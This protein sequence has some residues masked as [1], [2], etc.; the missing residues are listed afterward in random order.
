MEGGFGAFGKMPALG[1]FFQINAP[2]GFVRVWDDWLQRAM[3]AA[4][5]TIGTAWDD[6]YLS[7]PIW[8]FSLA[9]GIAGPAN[10][11]GVLMPSVDRVGR[12]FPLALMTSVAGPSAA[13]LDHLTSDATFDS[14]E[15]L[16]LACLE[17]AMDRDKLAAALAQIPQPA[18]NHPA[19]VYRKAGALVM[20]QA[21]ATGFAPELAT[22]LLGA[23]G[24][25]TPSVWS[26]I[27]GDSRRAMICDG[28]PDA[29]QV[30]ALYDMNSP[31]WA[32]AGPQT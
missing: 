10:V 6:Q 2:K 12:R 13:A 7:A 18:Q 15:D 19:P 28:L 24:F 31:F 11:I 20:P 21:P 17:D 16:A 8:R 14:L 25:S 23:G 30:P 1:D 29:R 3:V 27:L 22:A 4:A 5:D 9:P 26:T 32:D